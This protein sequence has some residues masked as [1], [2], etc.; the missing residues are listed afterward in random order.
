LLIRTLI[1]YHHSREHG[2][3]RSIRE[4]VET[5][6]LIHRERGSQDLAWAL[7]TSKPSDTLPP[8]RPHLLILL[9]LLK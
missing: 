1:H 5:Y 8:S 4:I 3:R 2:D 6:N 9:I 7:E